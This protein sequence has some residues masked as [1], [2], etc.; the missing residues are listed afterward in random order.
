MRLSFALG[1]P[2]SF[3]YAGEVELFPTPRRGEDPYTASPASFRAHYRI[4][5]RD[6]ERVLAAGLIAVMVA[7]HL[8][9]RFTLPPTDLPSFDL[10]QDVRLTPEGVAA[11]VRELW[12]LG[13][14]PIANM[15]Y[16]L[17]SKGVRV[18]RLVEEL[19]EVDAFAFWRGGT[20]YVI[21][22]TTK[23][24]ERSRFDAA[25]ELGHLLLHRGHDLC[26]RQAEDEANRFAAAFLL[27]ERPFR[28]MAPTAPILD[29]LLG[30]KSSWRVS[31]AAMVKRGSDLQLYSEWQARQAWIEL[32]RRGW[33]TQEPDPVPHEYSLLFAKIQELLARRGKAFQDI[34]EELHLPWSDVQAVLPLT[35]G[36]GDGRRQ[37]AESGTAAAQP[38]QERT[39]G[40]LR[41][42]VGGT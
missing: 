32:S 39:R 36:G 17:E 13:L 18:F 26:G 12:G 9:E 14:G 30:L 38:V 31:V 42:I 7:E 2:V 23:S 10:D 37:E 19:K 29:V 15:V 33:R 4:P 22:N 28:Q 1:F 27:P 16:L 41:L 34:A 20:P 11:A 8:A 3:F 35:L 6:R 21:L 25:H 40:H 5:A 24:G